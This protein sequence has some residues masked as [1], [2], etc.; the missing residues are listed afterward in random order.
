MEEGYDVT[1]PGK[2]RLSLQVMSYLEQDVY[3]VLADPDFCICM[4]CQRYVH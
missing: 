4:M 2:A 1:A 3:S